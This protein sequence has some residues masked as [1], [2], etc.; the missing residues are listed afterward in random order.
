MRKISSTWITFNNHIILV[1][2]LMDSN[3]KIYLKL[4]WGQIIRDKE[5]IKGA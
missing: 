4:P 5:S 2:V 1:T 3:N